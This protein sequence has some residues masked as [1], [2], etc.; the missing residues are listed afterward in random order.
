MKFAGALVILGAALL[1]LVTGGDC[2]ICPAI[3][4]DVHLFF[5][6]TPEEY[7]K[8]VEKYKD[9]LETLENKEK[10]KKCIDSKMTKEDKAH[11]TAIKEI[12]ASSSC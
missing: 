11:A 8:H 10:L 5:Y 2:G 3:K 12:E 7:V 4:Q 9:G 1:L 6:G